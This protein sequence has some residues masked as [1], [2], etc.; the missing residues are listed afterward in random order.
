MGLTIEYNRG[1]RQYEWVDPESG[2]IFTFPPK[3]KAA[4][5]QFA[6]AMLDGDLHDA[7]KNWVE[8]TPQLER[9]IWKAAELVANGSVTAVSPALHMVESSDG[10]GRYS[11]AE[12]LA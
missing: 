9:T 5:F 7:A 12:S 11:A 3:H 10:Y 1:E 2:E 6:L 4:A 8:E